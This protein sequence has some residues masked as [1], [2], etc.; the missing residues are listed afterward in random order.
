MGR[1]HL[2]RIATAARRLWRIVDALLDLSRLTRRE[3][4][5]ETVDLGAEARR[6][7]RGLALAEP[8]RRVEIDIEEGMVVCGDTALLSVVLENLF[9]NAWKFTRT[10]N[11]ARIRFGTVLEQEEATF[12]VE[13]NGVGF[14]M[15]HADRLFAPFERL[16]RPDEF[17]GV[18]IGLA[19]VQRIIR[20]HGGHI[21]A[22][23]APDR[24]ARFLFTL[25]R[26]AVA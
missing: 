25:P 7:L 18:G 1:K 17:E 8:H 22:E 19:S 15:A 4:V 6:V 26:D 20:R 3:L 12:V 21:R 5:P 23:S 24:G 2:A 16:H 11:P 14:D 10:R 13:D 9:A